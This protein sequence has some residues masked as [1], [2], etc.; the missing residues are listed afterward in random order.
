M[1]AETILKTELSVEYK[2][3]LRANVAHYSEF[4]DLHVHPTS[5]NGRFPKPL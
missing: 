4:K 5:G 2:Y 1:M 3:I